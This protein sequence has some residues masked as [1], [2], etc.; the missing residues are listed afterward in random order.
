MPVH[1]EAFAIFAG[2]HGLQPMT[3]ADH[4][5]LDEI[6]PEWPCPCAGTGGDST[7]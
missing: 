4:R 5:R 3:V 7:R 2:R 1:V 6:G